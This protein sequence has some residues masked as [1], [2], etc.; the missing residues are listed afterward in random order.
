MAWPPQPSP[1]RHS[2]NVAGSRDGMDN[3]TGTESLVSHRRERARRRNREEGNEAM[4][5]TSLGPLWAPQ[6][7]PGPPSSGGPL[8]EVPDPDTLDPSDPSAAL[9]S[10]CQLPGERVLEVAGAA[11]DFQGIPWPAPIPAVPT[12][13]RT[14][15]HPRGDRRRELGLPPDS[16]STV[17]SSELESS[18]FIDS[19]ED[20]NTSRWVRVRVQ[21]GAG[22]VPWTTHICVHGRVHVGRRPCWLLAV[23]RVGMVSSGSA[24][25]L[26][27]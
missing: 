15:G 23:C 11:H 22:C 16:A 7:P 25:P 3:E 14:N 4:P 27:L 20:D 18:S 8:A 24:L 21:G 5:L 2:P 1:P 17:L 26:P 12:A 6:A 9:K 10:P 13:A 19:D